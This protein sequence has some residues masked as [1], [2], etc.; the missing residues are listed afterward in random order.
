MAGEAIY[1]GRGIANK[2]PQVMS[3]GLHEASPFPLTTVDIH[4]LSLTDDEFKVHTWEEL[5]QI[6]GS[7][8]DSAQCLTA[9][10]ALS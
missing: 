10:N 8:L 6:I 4:N 3:S 1:A 9:P 7:Y 2:E 5:K